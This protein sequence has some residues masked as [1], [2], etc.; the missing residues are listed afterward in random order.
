MLLTR[1]AIRTSLRSNKR[2]GVERGASVVEAALVAPLFLLLIFGM[3]EGGSLFYTVNSARN[4]ARDGARE[5][6]TWASSSLADRNAL[7]SAKRALTGAGSRLNGVIIYKATSPNDPVPVDCLAALTGGSNGITDKCNAYSATK[8]QSLDDTH[9]GAE[10]SSPPGL[11]DEKWPPTQRNDALTPTQEPDF[12]G[13]YVSVTH[14]GITGI[15]PSRAI[16][17]TSVS[18]I[19]PQR[20]S[21]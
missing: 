21:E 8:L 14:V 2:S 20:T 9:F 17:H 3:I 16:S 5:A 11:W 6:T 18:R 15:L 12:V 13:V 1:V 4:A 10:S 19:E 7:S